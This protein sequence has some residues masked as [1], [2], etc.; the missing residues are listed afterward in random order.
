MHY[1][2]MHCVF[3]DIHFLV[4]ILLLG[5]RRYRDSSY[6][7]FIPLC[8]EFYL[9]SWKARMDSNLL[10]Y[11]LYRT[12]VDDGKYTIIQGCIRANSKFRSDVLF[13]QH[14]CVYFS[15]ANY[16]LILIIALKVLALVDSVL[17]FY[18]EVC[19]INSKVLIFAY[20]YGLRI[21]YWRWVLRREFNF[22][23]V[24]VPCC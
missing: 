17:F 4:S 15:V 14:Q 20:K 18:L 1:Y 9:H 13:I 24:I 5:Y 16:S 11:A 10:R 2:Y 21:G 12:L 22:S 8:F 6:I 3:N 23:K 19:Y 7:Y